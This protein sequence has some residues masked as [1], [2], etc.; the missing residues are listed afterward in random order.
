MSKRKQARDADDDEGSGSDVSLID[1][2]FEF[3]DPN[4]AV[5]YL[6]LKRLLTQLFQSDAELFALHDFADLVLSQPL[7]GTTVKIDGIEGDPYAYLSVLNMHAHQSHAS[8]K[9]LTAYVLA[10]SAALPALHAALQ[11]LLGPAGL[12]TQNH[13]GFVFSERLI[14]MPVQV[15]P[16]MYR[17]LADEIKWANDDKE[18]YTFTHY[19]VL[20]RTY[21]LTSDQAAELEN[22]AQRPSK[23][24]KNRPPPSAALAPGGGPSTYS[25]HPE[26][27]YIQKYATYTLDYPL[28]TQVPRDE[29]SFGLDMG[30][31][32]M[33]VSAESFQP[34]I[35]EMIAA[36]AVG[37]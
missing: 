34:M 1:V 21:R 36:Y 31:R 15:V 18:P 35:D 20:T 7:L 9:A 12:Q 28:T 8:I 23:R 29:D 19:L 3:F 27:E 30:G 25:F 13:V 10:K 16:P 32:M 2:D 26:D 37:Q 17:M 11:T 14:N 22:G 33:L 5:D 24:H 6:A 4:P